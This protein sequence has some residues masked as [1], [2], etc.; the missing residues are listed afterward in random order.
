MRADIVDW[1]KSGAHDL[2]VVFLNGPNRNKILHPK[3]YNVRL[4]IKVFG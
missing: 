3:M 4:R 2:P 1:T